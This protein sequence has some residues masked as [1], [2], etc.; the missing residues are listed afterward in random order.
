MSQPTV[1]VQL[2]KELRDRIE[3]RIRGTGFSSVD[4]FVAFVLARLTEAPPEGGEPLS[5]KDE[6]RV[7]Q[8]LRALGYID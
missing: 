4:D 8:R 3:A 6:A 1:A 2:P 7:K 5:A